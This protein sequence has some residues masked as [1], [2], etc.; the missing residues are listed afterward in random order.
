[1]PR[2]ELRGPG[3]SGYLVHS[4]ISVLVKLESNAIDECVAGGVTSIVVNSA[5]GA[6]DYSKSILS[7][8]RMVKDKQ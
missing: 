7:S 5:L 2:G 1:M 3:A 8:H 4:P 6:G